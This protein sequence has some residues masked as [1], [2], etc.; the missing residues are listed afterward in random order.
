VKYLVLPVLVAST[1]VSAAACRKSPAAE[2]KAADGQPAAAA[3]TPAQPELPAPV[4][5]MPAELPEVLAR[6]NGEAVTKAEFD[7]LVKNMEMSAGQPIPAERRDELLRKALD[8]LVTYTV[9]TQETKARNVAVADA[10]V[11]QNLQQMRQQFPDAKTFEQALSARGMTLERLR[12]DA[13]TDL[14]INKL[15]ETE[16]AGEPEATDAQVREFYDKSPD[17]FK[18]DEAVRASH[19]LIRVDPKA[20]AATRQ[21]A[22]TRAEGLAKDAK[23]GADFAKLAKEN[24]A[25]GSAAQGGDLNFMQRGQTVAPFDQAIFSM[26]PGQISDVVETEFGYHVIKVTEKRAASTVPYEQVSARIRDYLTQQGKQQRAQSFIE[27][28]KQKA[29]IEVLV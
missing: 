3:A 5:P 12:A 1:I 13:R 14:A 27:G 19:I 2:A 4:K 11:E 21:K 17:K 18:Q 28:L 9:L 6:V 16:V 26:Q 15:M 7:R 23:S 8:Q 20:D 22:R 29:K 10:E 24:S 25:D